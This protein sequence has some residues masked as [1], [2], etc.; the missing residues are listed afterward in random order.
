MADRIVVIEEGRISD[1]VSTSNLVAAD[2]TDL[3]DG[4]RRI[5]EAARHLDTMMDTIQSR[6]DR[7]DNDE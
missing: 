1:D 7:R 6:D 2:A 3:S 4:T 5:V